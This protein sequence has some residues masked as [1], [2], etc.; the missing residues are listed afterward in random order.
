MWDTRYNDL[1]RSS[2]PPFHLFC[3]SE[4]GFGAE[5]SRYHDDENIENRSV[6]R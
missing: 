4:A 6:S 5:G 1:F 2:L 3:I